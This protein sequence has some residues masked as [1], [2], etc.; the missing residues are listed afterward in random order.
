MIFESLKTK[1]A[2]LGPGQGEYGRNTLNETFWMVN[3]RRFPEILI[4]DSQ[5]FE[6][7]EGILVRE[8]LLRERVAKYS[9]VG[10]THFVRKFCKAAVP[11]S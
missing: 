8:F 5:Y 1:L 7:S 3:G 11:T 2:P 6:T 9:E 4:S 10:E